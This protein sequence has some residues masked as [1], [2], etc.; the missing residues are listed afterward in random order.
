[1][2][3][4]RVFSKLSSSVAVASTATVYVALP[5]LPFGPTTQFGIAAKAASDSGVN[6]TIDL[7]QSPDGSNWAA[8]EDVNTLLTLTSTSLKIAKFSPDVMP[9]NRLKLT[10]GAGN[11]ASTVIAILSITEVS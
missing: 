10:G 7:E 4:V 2:G 8:P 3:L 1:M 11:D 5:E 6:V 9:Y